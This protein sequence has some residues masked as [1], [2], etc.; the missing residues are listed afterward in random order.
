MLK[1]FEYL[2]RVKDFL[3]TTYSLDVLGNLDK[4]PLNT[5]S[6]LNEYYEKIADKVNRHRFTDPKNARADSYYIQKIKPFFVNQRIYYE[7]TFTQLNAIDFIYSNY[8]QN[9][10]K[11]S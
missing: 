4:F 6:T 5:D 8:L 2:L 9:K 1:Y 3:K 10:S 11:N 7:V